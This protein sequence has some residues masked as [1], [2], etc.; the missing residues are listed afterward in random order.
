MWLF[1]DKGFISVIADCIDPNR[2][3][4]RA[5][6]SEHIEAL[7]GEEWGSIEVLN[8]VHRSPRL[9]ADDYRF[10]RFVT[11]DQLREVLLQQVDRLQIGTFRDRIPDHDYFDACSHAKYEMYRMDRTI[12]PDIRDRMFGE[13]ED[14]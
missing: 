9:G 14:D 7:F 1:T 3:I 12:P 11:R 2:V 4:V 8:L 6:K 13:F 10:R 5:H